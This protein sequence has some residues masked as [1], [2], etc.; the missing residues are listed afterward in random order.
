MNLQEKL[1][2]IDMEGHYAI[3]NHIRD[4]GP[5]IQNANMDVNF[6]WGH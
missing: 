6:Y 2:D 3:Q 4:E 1:S 5:L